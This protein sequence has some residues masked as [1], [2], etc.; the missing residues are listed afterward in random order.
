MFHN[1]GEYETLALR[2]RAKAKLAMLQS[3]ITQIAKKTGMSSSVKLAMLTPSSTST[4]RNLEITNVL[5]TSF[6]YSVLTSS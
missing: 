5:N 1:K 3:E 4:V 2:E 6:N